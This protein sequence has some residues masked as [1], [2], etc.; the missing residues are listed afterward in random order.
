MK[1][2]IARVNTIVGD[3]NHN[4]NRIHY[5]AEQ[6]KARACQ[7]VVFSELVIPGYPS[8]DLLEKKDLM[9]NLLLLMVA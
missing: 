3:F 8:R 6:A 1:I 9:S 5:F 2:A 4:F 7:L